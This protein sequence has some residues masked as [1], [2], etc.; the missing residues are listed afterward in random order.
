[1]KILEVVEQSDRDKVGFIISLQE[2][3]E[4][5]PVIKQRNPEN[6]KL[7]SWVP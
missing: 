4:A 3:A 2:Y 5:Y 7:S 6:L 1:M